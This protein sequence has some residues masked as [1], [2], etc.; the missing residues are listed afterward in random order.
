MEDAE[1]TESNRR[2]LLGSLPPQVMSSDGPGSGLSPGSGGLGG[3]LVDC[4]DLIIRFLLVIDRDN[5]RW[6]YDA[7]FLAR[8]L[9]LLPRQEN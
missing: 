6:S 8:G 9:I 2:R 4:S 5:I 3:R 1:I 7:A